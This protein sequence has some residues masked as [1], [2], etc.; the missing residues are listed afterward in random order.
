MSAPPSPEE[1]YVCMCG[2]TTP[3][4]TQIAKWRFDPATGTYKCIACFGKHRVCLLFF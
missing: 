3:G 4:K 1:G 2:A